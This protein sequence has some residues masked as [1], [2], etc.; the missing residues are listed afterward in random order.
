VRYACPAA[1]ACT[2]SIICC[3]SAV[4]ARNPAAPASR[5]AVM[6]SL[7]SYAVRISTRVAVLAVMSRQISM[8]SRSG[9]W[10]SRTTTSGS[11]LSMSWIASWPVAASPRI[12]MSGSAVRMAV[13][14]ART[15]AW[16]STMTRLGMLRLPSG[17]QRETDTKHPGVV[18]AVDVEVSAAEAD[19]FGQADQAVAGRY[20][21]DVRRRV[22]AVR[23]RHSEGLALASDIDG[24]ISAWGVFLGVDERLA[25]GVVG[26]DR[27]Q[28]VQGDHR[29]IVAGQG[30]G[31]AGFSCARD[32]RVHR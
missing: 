21:S 32:E 12:S 11:R 9:S 28:R 10:R 4:L 5:A 16:S 8:P 14:P 15:A 7:I 17:C 30:D 24:H 3:G 29:R 19:A 20:R 23:D 31:S 2:A 26:G 18:G 22:L 13:T 25:E 27:D 6:L 1:T